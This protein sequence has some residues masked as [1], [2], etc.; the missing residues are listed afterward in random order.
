MLVKEEKGWLQFF[1]TG[2]RAGTGEILGAVTDQ[3]S[4][5]QTNKDVKQVWVVGQQQVRNVSSSEGCSN[6][7]LG[8]YTLVQAWAR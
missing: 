8:M 6:L 4:L 5:E 1:C 7:N 2:P 3:W